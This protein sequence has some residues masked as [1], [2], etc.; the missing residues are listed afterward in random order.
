MKKI[1]YIFLFATIFLSI[2]GN[3]QDRSR[4]SQYHLYPV[5]INPAYTGFNNNHN[6]LFNYRNSA[7]SF[8]GSPKDITFSYDGLVFDRLGLGAMIVSQKIGSL[9]NYRAQLS[10]AYQFDADDFKVSVGLTTEFLQSRLINKTVLDEFYED[11]DDLIAEAVDGLQFFDATLGFYTEYD[12]K[13]F[14]G[15]SVPNLIRARIDK[16]TTTT[17]DNTFFKYF[18]VQLG[19]RFLLEDYN[20]K[21]EPS[22]LVRRLRSAPFQADLNLKLS[23]LEDQ[24]IG[25][26]VYSLGGPN[27][28]GFLI[29]TRINNLM[30]SY[31]Y[32]IGLS[33]YQDYHN[34]AHDI[35]VGLKIDRK[36]KRVKL[37]EVNPGG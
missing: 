10:Y 20:F 28:V 7:A 5:L 25:G 24:L 2:E 11:G 16:A 22:L 8:P 23:F 35:S 21:V 17:T 13:V 14:F 33:D 9:Q 18:A 27:K 31:S 6:L 15:V 32:D 19:Y 37:E 30:L 34:G 12:E 4:Y 1:L 3:S 29:G 36:P 26:L